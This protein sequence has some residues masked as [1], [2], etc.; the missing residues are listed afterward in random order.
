MECLT[1]KSISGEQRISPGPPIFEGEHWMVEHAYP[2]ALLGWVVIVLR[3][4]ETALHNLSI[5][6]WRELAELQTRTTKAL[7]AKLTC[8][9]EYSVCFAE[10]PGFNHIHFHIIPR[11][12]E[13]PTHLKGPNIFSLLKVPQAEAIPGEEIAQFCTELQQQF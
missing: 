5:V 13:L 10:A 9:K 3:R 4:H 11:A 2:C 12:P 1:C 7:Y 6:E 8:E